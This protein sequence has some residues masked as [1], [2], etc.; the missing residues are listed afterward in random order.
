RLG[1]SRSDVCPA[2]HPAVAGVVVHAGVHDAVAVLVVVG[3][4]DQ[5]IAVVVVADEVGAT[6]VV[7]VGDDVH[8]TI[9]TFV[10]DVLVPVAIAV[11]VDPGVVVVRARRR[12]VERLTA[13]RLTDRVGGG[14]GAEALVAGGATPA[15]AHR[16]RAERLGIRRRLAQGAPGRCRA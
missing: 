3:D 14:D 15:V 12:R 6:V 8:A 7:H 5:P 16:G 4:V 11:H 13:G 1:G 9:S 2:I 10:V